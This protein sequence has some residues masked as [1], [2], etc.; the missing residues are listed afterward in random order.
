MRNK[1]V[2]FVFLM[3]FLGNAALA[4]DP[5]FSQFFASPV[6]TN[7]AFSG[8]TLTPKISLVYRNQ[9]HG[10]NDAYQTFGVSYDQS[11]EAY[12]SGFGAMALMDREGEG[13]YQTARFSGLYGYKL[14]FNHDWTIRFGVE[15]GFFQ[16]TI[17]WNRLIFTDQLNPITGQTDPLGNPGITEEIQPGDLQHAA[18]DVSAGILLYN[19]N[20]YVGLSVKHLNSPNQSLLAIN[21]NLNIG[22]P[23][24]ISFQAGTEITLDGR[25]NQKSRAFISPNLLVIKQGPFGQADV[26]AYFGLGQFFAGAWYRNGFENPDAA[27]FL[28]GFR[29]GI[30]RVGYS[31]DFTLSRLAVWNPGGTHEISI[32][33]NFDDSQ[34]QKRRRKAA[35]INDCFQIF[36]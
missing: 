14:N 8:V 36:R 2:A 22:L 18:L 20:F 34:Q 27:I 12:N 28:A 23:Y 31:F 16:K 1:L 6:F 29:E 13:I 9:W 7:P 3:V 17:D 32:T 15:A 25:N 11:L 21:D 30:L 26:G 24:L 33:L 19:S 35:R 4:Q 5:V 10:L